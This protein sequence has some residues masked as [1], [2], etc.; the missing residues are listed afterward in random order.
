MHRW[1]CHW[2]EIQVYLIIR[3]HT[4][5][6]RNRMTQ[7]GAQFNRESRIPHWFGSTSR[8]I[9]WVCGC[10]YS[11]KGANMSSYLFKHIAN[12][13]L[14][15][16]SAWERR[17]KRASRQHTRARAHTHTCTHTLS[18]ITLAGLDSGMRTCWIF[19][20]PPLLG[21]TFGRTKRFCVLLFASVTPTSTNTYPD[22][23]LRNEDS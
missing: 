14:F 23:N 13:L 1:T 19:L 10:I 11:G 8:S 4:K 18:V 21:C 6:Q 22:A 2:V 15:S 3:L 20:A 7:S 12:H 5:R 16:L 17:W 9:T